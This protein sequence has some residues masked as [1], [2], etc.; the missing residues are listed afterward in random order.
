VSGTLCMTV[1]V[2]D[3]AEGMAVLGH[4]VPGAG[5]KAHGAGRDNGLGALLDRLVSLPGRP[6]ITLFVVGRHARPL[7]GALA[8]FVAEGHEVASHG[9]DHGRLPAGGVVDWLRAGREV[10]EDLLGIAVHGFR[11][12]RFDLPP[13]APL[14]QYREWLAEAGYTYVSDSSLLGDGSPVRELPVLT[15]RGLPIGG[16]S[17]Q[18]F[19][20]TRMVA[21][22]VRA[23]TRPAVCYYHSYDFDG[24]V[25]P[26]RKV[27]TAALAKQALARGR[28][29]GVF[30]GLTEEFGS[31]T[32]GNVTS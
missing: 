22:A 17:Y 4:P 27:R 2:E 24:T 19:L 10:L 26:L 3:F 28:I 11:S 14:A 8:D 1:D 9:P 7:A 25:P 30:A 21:E 12:P 5:D 23:S 13:D 18:R 32:C 31:T 20:P 29:A 6:T 16:G 15:S